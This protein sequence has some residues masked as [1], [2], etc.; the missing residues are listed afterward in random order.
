[1]ADLTILAFELADKY[2]NPVMILSDGILG[3]M[4]EPVEF[5]KIFQN[6]LKPGCNGGLGKK[7]N[8]INSLYIARS[9]GRSQP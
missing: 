3:Q 8:V 4:M 9:T 1:M 5:N 6:R 2:R 7:R